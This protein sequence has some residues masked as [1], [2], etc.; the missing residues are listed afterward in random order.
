MISLTIREKTLLNII[1]KNKSITAKELSEKMNVS[2]RTI[3]TLI[4]NIRN[5]DLS[6]IFEIESRF[7]EGYQLV[8][9]DESTFDKL[10]NDSNSNAVLEDA[11]SRIN[12]IERKLLNG[13]TINI[14]KDCY[15]LYISERQLRS[16]LK[17]IEEELAKFHIQ[18]EKTVHGDASINGN[19]IDIRYALLKMNGNQNQQDFNKAEKII[20]EILNKHQIKM[21]D[22]QYK[23]FI[24]Y[25]LISIKRINQNHRIESISEELD[26]SGNQFGIANEIAG[27]IGN[28][29]KV[30]FSLYEIEGLYLCLIGSTSQNS[31]KSFVVTKEVESLLSEI[32]E[33][34]E[35]T[36][37]IDFTHNLGLKVSLS[38][39]FEPMINR[40]KHNM[41]V[42]NPIVGDIKKKYAMAYTLALTANSVIRKHY[43]KSLDDGEIGY[44]ALSFELAL[45]ESKKE[46]PKKKILL[47]CNLGRVSANL[48]RR[49]YL[50]TFTDY[51][52]EI[53][54]AS[55]NQLSVMN[56][57][58]FD[59]ILTTVP[60]RIDEY[61]PIPIIEINYFISTQDEIKIKR[62]LKE[63]EASDIEKYF[64]ENCFIPNL[65]AKTKEEALRVMSKRLMQKY[66][67]KEDLYDSV[68]RREQMAST[69][70]CYKTAMPHTD[71]LISEKSHV[72]IGILKEPIIWDEN[73]IQLIFLVSVGKD[74][75]ESQE[76]YSLISKFVLNEKMI[77]QLI[78]TSSY[79]IFIKTI[80]QLKG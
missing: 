5:T 53:E 32:F 57:S 48:L 64:N 15:E 74:R 22:M 47:V 40:L 4:K 26:L 61:I 10:I 28:T 69:D 31:N 36:Y 42:D 38:M 19:E 1:K 30:V 75:K 67:F 29:F 2:D 68:I 46:I 13:E 59:F 18:L 70:F 3:R 7:G 34:I 78:N 49:N 80:S 39:H 52:E 62:I 20:N 8:I 54:T 63:N 41:F 50:E 60:I 56:L 79:E 72:C 11:E 23:N 14:N 24:N 25:I 17:K 43:D 73:E 6:N 77:D 44:I 58:R 37:A 12:Y 66:E 76:F 16:D 21:N 65:K 33:L 35:S 71:K 9:K 55:L 27:C 45:E 51:I